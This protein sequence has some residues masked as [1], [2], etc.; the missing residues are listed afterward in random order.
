M[1]NSIGHSPFSVRRFQPSFLG[2]I[3]PFLP[4]VVNREQR[5]VGALPNIWQGR[6]AAR[7]RDT[8]DREGESALRVCSD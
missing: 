5:G 7:G 4:G 2:S 8:D 3:A 1:P 6:H